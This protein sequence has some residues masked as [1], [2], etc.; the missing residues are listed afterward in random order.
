MK[1]VI[2][3]ESDNPKL[4]GDE[5][6]SIE[7]LDPALYS[8]KVSNCFIRKLPPRAVCNDYNF[9][10]YTNGLTKGINYVLDKLEGK[11]G[12]YDFADLIPT[13]EEK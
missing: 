6:L 12:E 7:A 13:K 1:Y 2:V 10:S 9:E 8:I 4:E 5:V 11:N 3:F